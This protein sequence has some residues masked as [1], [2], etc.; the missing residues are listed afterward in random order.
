MHIRFILLKFMFTNF[1]LGNNKTINSIDRKFRK[2][3]DLI[4]F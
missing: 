1:S 2:P 3:A 4:V